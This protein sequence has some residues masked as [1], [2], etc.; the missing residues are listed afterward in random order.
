MK[1]ASSIATQTDATAAVAEAAETVQQELGS[2]TA[3]LV[4]VFASPHYRDTMVRLPS[5]IRDRFPRARL[6]GCTGGGIIGAGREIEHRPALS[7]TAAS[8]PGVELHPFHFDLDE[9]PTTPAAWHRVVDPSLDPSFLLLPEPF[10]CDIEQLISGLDAAFP[11]ARKV[12]GVASGG[13]GAGSN[14]LFL[15]NEMLRDGVV[16]LAL[17]GNVVMDTLVAQGCRPIGT[18]LLITRCEDNIILE[19]GG[20]PALMVLR[21]LFDT[22]DGRDKELFRSS[23]FLGIQMKDDQIEYRH[24]DFL[25]RNM[26][27]INPDRNAVVVG[28]RVTPYQAVQFHLRDAEASAEDLRQHLTAYSRSGH[29]PSGALLFS[30]LGRGENLYGQPDH[31]SNLIISYLGRLPVGGFFCNGEIGPVGEPTFLHGYTSSF[32]FVRPR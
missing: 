1:W 2:L 30:C 6:L 5:L 31:D 17:T 19:L 13:R 27:G 15:D 4:V 20:Q 11:A 28:A 12:G 16:G 3:D 24:G 14:A 10:S 21:A 25:I 23:L 32:A 18:P 8:L 26:M 22:L 29:K 7:I 9:L